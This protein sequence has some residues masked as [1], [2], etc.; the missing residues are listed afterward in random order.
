MTGLKVQDSKAPE[1]ARF[2]ACAILYCL[3]AHFVLTTFGSL[4]DLHPYI[5]VGCGL[6]DRGHTV[7]IATSEIYREKVVGENLRFFPV[8]P[9]VAGLIHDVNEMRR[10]FHPRTGSEY[11]LRRVFLPYIEQGFEDLL[12]LAREAD[13]LVGHP[14]AFA[15]PLVAEVLRKRWVSVILQPALLLSAW[16]PPTVSGVPVLDTFRGA[17]PWFWRR[18]L[19]IARFIAARWGKPVND[20]RRKLGLPPV[21]NPIFDDM[22]S[23]WGNQAW[24]SKVMAQPQPDWPAKMNVTGYTFYDKLNPGEG[25]SPELNRFLDAGSPPVVFTL[26]SSAVFDAGPFYRESAEAVRRLGCR[27]VLLI[28]NDPRNLPAAPLP[29]S[30]FLAPYAPY[31]EL[32]PRAA[33][34]VHQGGSGTTAQ[35]LASGKPM[36]VV[37][38][39]HDQPDNARRVVK[40]GGARTIPRDQYRAGRLMADL[41]PLLQ[42]TAYREAAQRTAAEMAREDGVANACDGLE[43]A[44]K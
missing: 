25:M 13:L 7:T 6:R 41:E 35:A 20:L 14:V 29:D 19:R 28:G 40:L 36:I 5:A 32:F 24:F 38:Y 33:V 42:D 44:L 15:T 18:F 10:A 22:F 12:P 30:I 31:S 37:P 11:I 9:D 23:P 43:A 8:R 27:A 26:G 34:T 1:L 21:R 39:S 17:G 16:D 3:G 2:R 4:G